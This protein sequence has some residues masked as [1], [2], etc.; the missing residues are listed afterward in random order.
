R[1]S[2][3]WPHF[4]EDVEKL[5]LVWINE[6]QVAGDT[7]RESFICSKAKALYI[8]LVSTLPGMST[9][10]EEGFEASKGWF[11]NLKRRN[12]ICSVVRHRSSLCC[13][14]QH[15]EAASLDAK[16]AE[17]FATEFQKLMVSKCYLLEQVFNCEETGLFWKRC[18]R[19]PTLQKKRV[20]H[21][22]PMKDCLTLL[23]CA[24]A[25]GDFKVKPLLIYHS[26]NSQTF[27]N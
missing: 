20:P 21:Q 26:E 25:S 4:L 7:V 24:N 11:D 27:K 12:G 13:A 18:Q 23:F 9:E 16:A 17:A 6:K 14:S 10:N 22:K 8:N 1:M 19:G 2:K 3:Q 15:R 5:L